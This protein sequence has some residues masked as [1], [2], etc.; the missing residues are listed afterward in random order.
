MAKVVPINGSVK[1]R[2]PGPRDRIVLVGTTGS[3][4]TQG[5]LWHLSNASFTARPWIIIDP[6]GEEKFEL[7]E[8]AEQ[9][10]VGELPKYPGIYIVRP[11]PSEFEQLDAMLMDIWEREN[12]G[13]Y[14]D[15]GYM[16]GDGAGITACLTQGRS[17]YIPM[18]MLCQRPVFVSRF[19]FSEASFIQVFDLVDK[20]DARIVHDNLAPIPFK[21]HEKLIPDYHSWYW[22]ARQKR[23]F[24][25]KPVPS[26]DVIIDKINTRLEDYLRTRKRVRY[27]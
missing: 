12:I 8:Y 6:K 25:M 5:A 27:F 1:V 26:Q 22:D 24:V 9:I 18:I 3:G 2:L 19:V 14:S 11:I 21:Q 7:L 10:R 15:E 20:R 16:A 23:L 17:K 13:I 4:K